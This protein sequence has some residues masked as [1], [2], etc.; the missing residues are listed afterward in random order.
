MGM[1]CSQGNWHPWG[2]ADHLT[3]PQEVETD[4]PRSAGNADTKITSS[5]QFKEKQFPTI[6]HIYTR[7]LGAR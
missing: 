7:E 5:S 6:T 3:H 2:G 1:A 4:L